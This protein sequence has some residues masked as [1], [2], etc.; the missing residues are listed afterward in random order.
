MQGS[1]CVHEIVCM[2]VCV[3]LCILQMSLRP[4]LLWE[5]GLVYMGSLCLTELKIQSLNVQG[6][7]GLN[8]LILS[9]NCR[10]EFL[11]RFVPLSVL[12]MSWFIGKT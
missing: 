11:L 7:L 4:N 12:L 3:Y 10:D 1:L 9:C 6:G 5:N 2:Y 8:A